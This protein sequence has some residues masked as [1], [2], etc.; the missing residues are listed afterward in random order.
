MNSL[1]TA[2]IIPLIL[3][4]ICFDDFI[5]GHLESFSQSWSEWNPELHTIYWTDRTLRLF[6]AERAPEYSPLFDGCVHDV[7]RSN[8]ARYLLMQYYG[9][10]VVDLDCQCLCP[11]EPLLQGRELLI[12]LEPV[13]HRQQI[14]VEERGMQ[15]L[16]R[17]AFIA[18]RPGHPFW[19]DV[20]AVLCRSE[21]LS[22]HTQLDFRDETGSLLLGDVAKTKPEYEACL[23]PP[24]R[25]Y[26]FSREECYQGLVYDPVFWLERSSAAFMACYWDDLWRPPFASEGWHAFVPSQAPVNVSSRLLCKD[27]RVKHEPGPSTA[28][29]KESCPMISCLMIT[30]GRPFQA[31]L[32]IQSFLRQSYLRRELIVVDDDSDSQLCDWILTLNSDLIRYF[33]LPDEGLSLGELRNFSARQALGD[34]VC[35]WDDDDLFDPLRL[36]M[37]MA[38]LISSG[39]DAI[40]LAR[41]LIWWPQYKRLAVS[42]FR[43]WEGS[44]LCRSDCLP[45]YPPLRQGEDSALFETLREKLILARIDMPRLYLYVVHGRNTFNPSHFDY[46]WNLATTRWQGDDLERLRPELQRRL[47]MREYAECV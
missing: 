35:Q 3:H 4:Q 20:L 27:I 19:T 41:F 45:E 23:A 2:Q 8:L 33:R 21:P 29:M 14:N 17:T 43:D 44:L 26:P 5:P 39:S 32:S 15:A 18:S 36:E 30:R 6:V 7:C 34:Y 37:Q 24:A 46:H 47:F 13:L 40:V 1:E 38:A 31:R 16:A 9:G 12:A 28:G 22:A 42:C 25:M 10:I 11:I